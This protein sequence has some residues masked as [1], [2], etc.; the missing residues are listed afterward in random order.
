MKQALLTLFGATTVI[1]VA[2]SVLLSGGGTVPPQRERVVFWHFWGGGERKAVQSIVRRFNQSQ[3]RYWVDEVPVPGQ[4][5]D[6][7]FF[8]A[9]AGGDFPDVL[10]QDDQ[11][12]AQWAD[13]DVLI[14]IRELT[15]GQQEY[16]RLVDWLNPAARS[17][18]T[19]N[20]QLY[21]LCNAIDVRTLIYRTDTLADRPPPVT[22]A[23]LGEIAKRD[24]GDDSSIFYLPDDRRL[25]AWGIVFGGDFYDEPTGR[26]T[27]NDPKIVEALEWMVS[28]T[29][30]HGRQKIRAFRS[31]N[32]EAGAGSMLLDGRYGLMMDGQWRIPELDMARQQ[33][34][35][36]GREPIRYGVVALPAPPGGRTNAG[37]LNGNFF[38]VPRGCK[39][40]QGAWEFMKFWSGFGGHEAE[41]AITA[42]SGGWIPASPQVVEQPVFEDYLQQHPNFRLFVELASSPHQVP[43]PPIPVQAYFYERINRAAEEALSLTKTPQQ[44]LDD[45][46]RDIQTRLVAVLKS[47]ESIGSPLPG[48]N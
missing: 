43:T 33:A 42:T 46:T 3:D 15:M 6:M 45:A 24:S 35:E 44:A 21:A 7:K 20:G 29:R 4:N 18:G 14:P 28:Y 48:R 32:R 39:N 41:A 38:V 10:N 1:G 8:M 25:W 13:R 30:F 37:W 36:Q 47:S 5:L 34:L 23:Q 12:I 31:T 16:K 17:I 22:L 26:V 40:P 27:A 2:F 11:I 9:L 19:Y